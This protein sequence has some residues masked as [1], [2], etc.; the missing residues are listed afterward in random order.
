[1]LA[2]TYIVKMVAMPEPDEVVV[3]YHRPPVVQMNL[4]D[5]T[6]DP[7]IDLPRFAEALEAQLRATA[8]MDTIAAFWRHADCT[9]CHC[10]PP[11]T[12]VV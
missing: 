7:A 8:E 3:W 10:E 11:C 12:E 5:L 1:M 2:A 6:G 4:D 9:P